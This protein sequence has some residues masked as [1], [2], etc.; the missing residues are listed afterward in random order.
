MSRPSEPRTT[1]WLDAFLFWDAVIVAILMFIDW[2]VGK[3]GRESIRNVVAA[4]WIRINDNTFTGLVA[5][6]AALLR[7]RFVQ[8]FGHGVFSLKR[9]LRAPLVGVLL[10]W[11]LFPFCMI[12][13]FVVL[14]PL[15]TNTP[16]NLFSGELWA[17]AV[18][19]LPVY[20][21]WLWPGL[22]L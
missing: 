16:V 12:L 15:G 7:S 1:A 9:T 14:L 6:D 21:L 10:A 4:W 8:W 2:A 18:Q 13:W 11:A 22:T 20:A 19:N 17:V 5:A 3:R